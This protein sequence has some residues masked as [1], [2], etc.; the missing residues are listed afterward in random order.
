MAIDPTWLKTNVYNIIMDGVSTTEEKI[1]ELAAELTGLTPP[2]G[3]S[4]TVGSNSEPIKAGPVQIYN[5]GAIRKNVDDFKI[6]HS[7]H[8]STTISLPNGKKRT[9]GLRKSGYSPAFQPFLD[10]DD[11]KKYI[12]NDN[13]Y[14]HVVYDLTILQNGRNQP[15]GIHAPFDCKVVFTRGNPNSAIGLIGIGPAKGKTA[16]F[17]HILPSTQNKSTKTQF[18]ESVHKQLQQETL[19]KTF[20][21]GQLIAYQGNWGQYSTGTHLHV[22]AMTKEDFDRYI[23][24]LPTFYK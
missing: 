4:E 12:N 3:G 21:K 23:T 19:N 6:H 2:G 16:I 17:L 18:P 22:E 9:I 1:M 11:W 15:V 10:K 8:R 13:S 5:G 7:T 24:E 20:K 14:K